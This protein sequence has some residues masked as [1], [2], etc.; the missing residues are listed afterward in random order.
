MAQKITH[1]KTGTWYHGIDGRHKIGQGRDMFG[2]KYSYKPSKT[3]KSHR[4]SSSGYSYVSSGASYSGSTPSTLAILWD[5]FLVVCII[6]GAIGWAVCAF[7]DWLDAAD[8][9]RARRLRD[10]RR[11]YGQVI[12]YQQKEFINPENTIV[13]TLS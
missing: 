1:T 5:L 12:N 11:K 2:N 13:F 3:K 4:S 9:K 10:Y 8:K 7:N 6:V